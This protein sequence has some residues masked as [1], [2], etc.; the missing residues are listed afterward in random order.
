MK[1]IV[2]MI[3]IVQAILYVEIAIVEQIF[4]HWQIV[5]RNLT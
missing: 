2:M 5:A 1:E 4:T 3:R